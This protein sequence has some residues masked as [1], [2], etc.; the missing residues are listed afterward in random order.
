MEMM[1]YRWLDW[2]PCKHSEKYENNHHVCLYMYDNDRM[3]F[4]YIHDEDDSGFRLEHSCFFRFEQND[5]S[6]HLITCMH[7]DKMF[8]N[9]HNESCKSRKCTKFFCSFVRIKKWCMICRWHHIAVCVWTRQTST[10]SL[11]HIW[12]QHNDNSI[13]TWPIDVGLMC[14]MRERKNEESSNVFVVMHPN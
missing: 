8:M 2:I 9:L 1:T 6:L 11:R 13:K 12:I 14:E 10:P 7:T 5:P 3:H 4:F